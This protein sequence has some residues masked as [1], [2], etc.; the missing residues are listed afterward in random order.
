MY[1]FLLFPFLDEDA[2]KVENYIILY[3]I[4][5]IRLSHF[6]LSLVPP[7]RSLCD[8]AFAHYPNGS[9]E[10]YFSAKENLTLSV[11]STNQSTAIATRDILTTPLGGVGA[12]GVPSLGDMA[13]GGWSQSPVDYTRN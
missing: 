6:S 10:H 11:T 5:F 3:F 9:I 7:S 1:L 2:G 4:F 8:S 12:F 13:R